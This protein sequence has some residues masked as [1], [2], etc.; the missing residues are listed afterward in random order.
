MIIANTTEVSTYDLYSH[1][2]FIFPLFQ[3]TTRISTYDSY[4]H[5]RF[6]FPHTIHISTYDPHFHVRPTFPHTIKY[7]HIRPMIVTHTINIIG[8]FSEMLQT[9]VVGVFGRLYSKKCPQSYF[10]LLQN[11]KTHD[12]HHCFIYVGL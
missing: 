5:I 6:I 11:F 3:H 2:R 8:P 10:F 1:I 9:A 7:S 12:S 4:S